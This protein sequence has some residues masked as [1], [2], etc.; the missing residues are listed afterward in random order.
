MPVDFLAE[1]IQSNRDPIS[2][3]QPLFS[4]GGRSLFGTFKV[5][6]VH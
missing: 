2:T 5:R 3:D 6:L 4:T 1:I